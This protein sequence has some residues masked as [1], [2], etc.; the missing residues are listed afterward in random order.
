M[1]Q[2]PFFLLIGLAVSLGG[3]A[4][5]PPPGGCA[6]RVSSDFCPHVVQA[7]HRMPLRRVMA[8]HGR[9]S[10]PVAVLARLAKKDAPEPRINSTTWW[11]GENARLAKAITIC[12]GCLPAPVEMV[13]AAKPGAAS[14]KGAV[15]DVSTT[16][17]LRSP[18]L[19]KVEMPVL[20][21]PSDRP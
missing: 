3:C 12:K 19:K 16:S 14:A 10:P 4:S 18:A 13:S 20:T 2:L 21:A 1:R 5:S 17:S 15:Q 7:E 9:P 11:S 6:G 8:A